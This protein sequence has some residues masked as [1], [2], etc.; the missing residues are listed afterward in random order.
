MRPTIRQLEYVVALAESLNFRRAA[1]TCHAT[2]PALSAQLRQLETAIGSTL[3]E[4]DRRR[5][6]LTPAGEAFLPHARAVL[7]AADDAVAAVQTLRDPLA[8][9]LR[10]GVIPTVAPY[11]LPRALPR[12]RKRFP[13]LRLLLVEERTSELVRRLQEGRLDA[14]LLALE[15][16]LGEVEQRVLFADPFLLA[17]PKGHALAERKRLKESDLNNEEVML[18]EDGHC[19]RYQAMEVW[20]PGQERRGG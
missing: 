3:F 16:D 18:L 7:A 13:E 12:V 14:A 2:Q 17:V 10:L 19:L 6:L 4:R 20:P 8:G 15:A 5:V 9:E 1:E 11:V